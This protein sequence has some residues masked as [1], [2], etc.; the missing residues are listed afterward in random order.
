M[1]I[2]EFAEA[3]LYSADMTLKLGDPGE[4]TDRSPGSP[5]AVPRAPGRP[6][7]LQMRTSKV[8]PPAPTVGALGDE[9]ARGL[10]LHSFAHHELQALELMAL[11]LLRFPDA[12]AGFRRGLVKIIT[13][14]QRH[15]KMYMARAEHWGVGLGDV[16]TGH[17][18]WD[19]VAHLDTPA[20]FLAALSLTYEQANLDFAWHWEEAFRAV[21]DEASARVLRVVHDDEIAH[22]R[23]GVAWFDRLNGG[24]TFEDYARRLVFPLS[25]G[26][27]KGPRFDRESRLRAGLS[28]AFVDEMEIT[29]VSRGRPPRV[30]HFDP[31]VEEQAAGR[32]P[33]KA[34]RSVAQDLAAVSMFF[35]HR[36]DVVIAKR[37]SL[38]VLLGLH[39]IG[40]PI[41][42]FVRDE[43]ELCDRILG[44][45]TPWGHPEQV[46]AVDKVE[47]FTL[48]GR[49]IE[50]HENPL[51][52][53]RSGH[54][55][56]AIDAVP[57][58]ENWVAKAPLSASGQHRV[59]LD[60]ASAKAW[61]GKQL[62]T[63]PILVEPWHDKIL[64]LSVQIH[65]DD[66]GIRQLG[67]NRFWTT[68]NGAYRGAVL[69]PWTAGVDP[70]VL[71][72]LH[73]GGRGSQIKLM[74]KQVGEFVGK[75]MHQ[76]GIR[77]PVGVDCMVIRQSDEV[78]VLPILEINPR[79]TMGR[80]AIELHRSTGLRGGWFFVDDSTC[81]DAGFPTRTAFVETV[82]STTGATFTTD[83]ETAIR[84]MTVMAGGK[85]FA[86]AQECWT[87]LGFDWPV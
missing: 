9:Q 30:F 22:V 85:S 71:R 34:A 19:T 77:G 37:P 83:P 32:T 29:N 41:P 53:D 39:R 64:D 13:D 51:W 4:V 20:D 33:A 42:Q 79:Y 58:G 45:N 38:K 21:D 10:A 12:P 35:A 60:H 11:A 80:V 47:A 15:F 62:K 82:H 40:I 14:E 5:C 52:A 31:F 66:G 81:K 18:F 86:D 7:G 48:R 28:E 17:F 54:I 75:Q 73:G 61:I 49:F 3:V 84:T 43:A 26:R 74:L 76:R 65:I 72:T 6:D 50:T 69:G 8:I 16:G 25:P 23:H 55:C 46:A 36:E 56:T 2:R 67:V 1:D 78:R 59:R 87:G 70:D 63:G 68:S 44:E 24:V 27:A 57:L